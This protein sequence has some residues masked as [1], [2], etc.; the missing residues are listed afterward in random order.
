[1]SLTTQLTAVPADLIGAQGV[2]TPKPM[3]REPKKT[4][5]IAEPAVDAGQRLVIRPGDKD[6]LMIYT[7]LD[8]A[9]GRVIAQIPNEV[10]VSL[11]S[12]PDYEAGQVIN[13][14]A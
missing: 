9:S 14:K 10:A 2:N 1:M 5:A 12:R 3:D 13:A 6:G 4:K 11:A 8:G 7:I